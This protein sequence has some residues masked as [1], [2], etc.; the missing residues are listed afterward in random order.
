M[1]KLQRLD[2]NE[3]VCRFEHAA[4]GDLLHIDIKKLAKF[5]QPGYRITSEQQRRPM[6]KGT[7]LWR[8]PLATGLY[9]E[10]LKDE[11]DETAAAFLEQATEYF[12]KRGVPVNEVMTDNGACYRSKVFRNIC[13]RFDLRH[14]FTRPYRPQTNG[15]AARFIK[16]LIYE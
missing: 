2:S 8:R 1:G 14:P 16:T 13:E 10:V 5:D 4:A 9:V 7:R 6:G 3:P 12:Q 11:K 15:K